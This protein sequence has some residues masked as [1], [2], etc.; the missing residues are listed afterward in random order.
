MLYEER[1][2]EIKRAVTI[3]D[4]CLSR[5]KAMLAQKLLGLFLLTEIR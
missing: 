4:V 2:P 3:G 1:S 5:S